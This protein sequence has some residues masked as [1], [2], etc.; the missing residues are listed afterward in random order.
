MDIWRQSLRRRKARTFLFRLDPPPPEIWE[1]RVTE[2]VVQARLLGRFAEPD[3]LVLVKFFTR[4]LL[5]EKGSSQWAAGM[6]TCEN[7][8]K[9][10]FGTCVPFAGSKHQRLCDGEL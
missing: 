3:T 9:E 4:Q 7:I 8:W 1:I 5:G 10:L 2:P 6:A